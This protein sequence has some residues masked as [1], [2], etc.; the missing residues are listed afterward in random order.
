MKSSCGTKRCSDRGAGNQSWKMAT[1]Q[2]T[3]NCL[4]QETA[5][6]CEN[7]IYLSVPGPYSSG[8]TVYL[9]AQMR[10]TVMQ[11][12][13]VLLY[14]YKM[15]IACTVQETGG[16]NRDNNFCHCNGFS[17]SSSFKVMFLWY[18]IAFLL[19]TPRNDRTA[20]FLFSVVS[21]SWSRNHDA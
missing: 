16:G 14:Y 21:D 2:D 10:Y 1:M 4:T 19:T 7:P 17:W 3:W 8:G 6:D 15:Q 18:M 12:L 20:W 13:L 5:T 11:K 9:W